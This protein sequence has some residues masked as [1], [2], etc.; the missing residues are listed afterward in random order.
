M[1]VLSIR[2][3]TSPKIKGPRIG[4]PIYLRP[5]CLFFVN[6]ILFMTWGASIEPPIH[7]R[8]HQMFYGMVDIPQWPVVFSKI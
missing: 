5:S 6:S 3:N 7:C 4:G 1:Y 2:T 8:M